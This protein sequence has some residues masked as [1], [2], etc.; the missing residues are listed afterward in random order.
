ML[1]E[2]HVMVIPSRVDAGLKADIL[3][4]CP[5]VKVTAVGLIPLNGILPMTLQLAEVT[6]HCTETNI[7]P[8]TSLIVIEPDVSVYVQNLIHL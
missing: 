3:M 5:A 6:S 4:P 1:P 2:I 7:A 8:S